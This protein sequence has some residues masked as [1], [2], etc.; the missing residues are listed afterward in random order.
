MKKETKQKKYIDIVHI[1]NWQMPGQH[2]LIQTLNQI[3][4]LPKEFFSTKYYEFKLMY[5]L[6]VFGE[7]LP[8]YALHDVHW[9]GDS[10]VNK[11]NVSLIKSVV[12]FTFCHLFK[13]H[14]NILVLILYYVS[15]NFFFTNFFM[16]CKKR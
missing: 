14:I 6:C 12:L 7:S 10:T 2:C 8:A 3:F 9:V 13:F 1:P 4:L 5:V 15:R 16:N 11:C